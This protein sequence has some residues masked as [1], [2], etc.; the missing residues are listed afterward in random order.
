MVIW[1]LF[2]L[3]IQ[4]KSSSYR[5]LVK[6]RL[7]FYGGADWIEPATYLPSLFTKKSLCFQRD[8]IEWRCYILNLFLTSISSVVNPTCVGGNNKIP[9]RRAEGLEEN[10]NETLYPLLI[11]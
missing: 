3:T 1:D 7:D 2:Y 6:G 9:L 11:F 8:Q 4:Y 5:F 10:W